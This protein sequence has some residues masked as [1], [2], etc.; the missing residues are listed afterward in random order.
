M[1]P[2]ARR[3]PPQLAYPF[4]FQN[5]TRCFIDTTLLGGRR[6]CGCSKCMWWEGGSG[7]V[8]TSC[9]NRGAVFSAV[10]TW[11]GSALPNATAG[12]WRDALPVLRLLLAGE[13]GLLH[14]G[15]SKRRRGLACRRRRDTA[16]T[17]RTTGAQELSACYHQRTSIAVLHLDRS[18]CLK[19]VFWQ[20][21]QRT[22]FPLPLPSA[23]NNNTEARPHSV[24]QPSEPIVFR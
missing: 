2:G 9:H 6:R 21:Q 18:L 15:A 3:L 4:I 10:R 22:C 8:C 19:L 24:K 7:W 16:A 1:Q 5:N 13:N 17:H 14:V 23:I 20:H 11:K 12:R